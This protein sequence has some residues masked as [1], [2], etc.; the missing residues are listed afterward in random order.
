MP[1][2]NVSS[3]T[4]QKQISS[5][6]GLFYKGTNLILKGSALLT[7]LPH[8]TLELETGTQCVSWEVKFEHQDQ[9]R[10]YANTLILSL[11]DLRVHTE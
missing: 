1:L 10:S 7:S 11:K 9:G 8:D 5:S 2:S 4:P 6:S 3:G